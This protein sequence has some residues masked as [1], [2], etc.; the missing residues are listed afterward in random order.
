MAAVAAVA[1]VGV[2]AVVV[3]VAATVA[4]P[5]ALAARSRTHRRVGLVVRPPRAAALVLAEGTVGTQHLE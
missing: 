5:T 3:V 4:V 1:A 2:A